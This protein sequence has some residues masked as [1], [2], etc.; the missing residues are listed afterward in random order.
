MKAVRVEQLLNENARRFGTR[1]AIVCGRARHSFACIEQKAER[2]AGA[3]SARGIGEG[4]RVAMFMGNS[5]EAV[6]AIFAVLKTGAVLCPIEADTGPGKLAALLASVGAVAIATEARVASIAA[7]AVTSV[8]DVRVVVLAGGDR[9]TSAGDCI[10]LEAAI[11]GF[12]PPA[13]PPVAGDSSAPA[14]IIMAG[15]LGALTLTHDDLVGAAVDADLREGTVVSARVSLATHHGLHQ[16]LTALA[17]G[18]TQVFGGT[19]EKDR[20]RLR[21]A[22]IRQAAQLRL[23]CAA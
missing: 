11:G 6:I 17:A 21:Q 7:E 12:M 9:A 16:M 18:A 20:D 10:A 19:S 3:L 4:D 15:G 8:A 14:L 5:A 22:E 13:R 2:L 23:V 1:T